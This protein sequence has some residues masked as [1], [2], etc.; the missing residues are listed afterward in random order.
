[1]S[2][3]TVFARGLRVVGGVTI[4]I[5]IYI[6]IYIWIVGAMRFIALISVPHG[7]YATET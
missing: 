1:M 3:F 5:Y 2:V 4:Y 6:C 7:L